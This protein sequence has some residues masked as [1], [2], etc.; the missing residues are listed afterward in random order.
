MVRITVPEHRHFSAAESPFLAIVSPVAHQDSAYSPLALVE[1]CD[2]FDC[3][4]SGL[5]RWRKV[6][7]AAVTD[8]WIQKKIDTASREKR[9]ESYQ[10]A[11]H[12][13]GRCVSLNS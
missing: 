8:L 9:C 5:G 13:V 10:T 11:L 12:C 4:R 6:P 7:P 1:K 2:R 3:A